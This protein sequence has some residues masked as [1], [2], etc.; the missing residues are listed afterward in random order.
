[1][2]RKSD[3]LVAIKEVAELSGL[4]VPTLCRYENEGKMPR[5]IRYSPRCVRWPRPIIMQ[6]LQGEWEPTP[7]S[8][9]GEV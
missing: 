6:W 2:S 4:S 3:H 1:M 9:N 5:A 7:I 8:S